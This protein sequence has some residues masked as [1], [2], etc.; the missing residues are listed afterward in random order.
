M[1]APELKVTPPRR[2]YSFQDHGA[3]LATAQATGYQD[4]TYFKCDATM[5][6]KS[7]DAV[8]IDFL[9]AAQE[10]RGLGWGHNNHFIGFNNNRTGEFVQFMHYGRLEWYAD[11]PI[12]SKSGDWK[13]YVWGCHTDTE[14][15]LNTLE[16]FFEEGQWFDSLDFAMGRYKK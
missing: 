8:R 12:D 16:L 9:Q 6:V 7:D 14:S 5:Q 1:V 10:M 15:V 2:L 3:D 11:V 13:G 4:I